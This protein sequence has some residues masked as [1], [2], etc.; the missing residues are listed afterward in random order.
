MH[1]YVN[2]NLPISFRNLFTQVMDGHSY[3]T[4]Q[5]GLF[6]VPRTKSRFVDKLPLYLFPN[7]WNKH[8]PDIN[9]QVSRKQFKRLLKNTCLAAYQSTVTC[10]NI[11]CRTCQV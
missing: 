7:L 9:T 8:S 6:T 5:C 11:Y 3:L 1:D 2:S 10:N 4:R